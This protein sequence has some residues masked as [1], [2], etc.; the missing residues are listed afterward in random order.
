MSDVLEVKARVLVDVGTDERLAMKA[1]ADVRPIDPIVESPHMV[2][3][4]V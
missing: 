3:E 4:S 2:K 1:N